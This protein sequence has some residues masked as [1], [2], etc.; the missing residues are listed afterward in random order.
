MT[1]IIP[2]CVAIALLALVAAPA[3]AQGVTQRDHFDCS[4]DLFDADNRIAACTR[5]IKA[6]TFHPRY[7]ADAFVNRAHA[8]AVKRAYERAIEDFGRALQR[9][10][11]SKDAYLFRADTYATMGRFELALRDIDTAIRLDA[12]MPIAHAIR[13]RTHAGMERLEAAEKDCVEANRLEPGNLFPG[14]RALVHLRLGRIDAALADY[15]VALRMLGT[16]EMSARFARELYG[17]GVARRIKGDAAGSHADI[18]RATAYNPDIAAEM[19]R[20]GVK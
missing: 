11:A 16:L 6:G 20:Y 2:T 1:R 3:T 7:I 10:P 4:L 9:D 18:A 15:D 19:A 12:S 8:L 13:C 14:E 5:I 17:R